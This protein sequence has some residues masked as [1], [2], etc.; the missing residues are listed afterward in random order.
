[1]KV[2]RDHD[3]LYLQEDRKQ[4]TKESFKFIVSKASAHLDQYHQPRIADI[5]CATGDFLYYLKSL[6][7]ES[8][9]TGIDVMPELLERAAAEVPGVEFLQGNIV[10]K[11]TLPKG[12]F[13]AVFMNGVY[14]IFDDFRPCLE[15]ALELADRARDGKLFVFGLFNPDD[16][17]VLV[18]V[19]NSA[20]PHDAPWQ[21]GWN[22]FSRTSVQHHLEKLGVTSSRFHEFEIGIDLPRHESDPLRSWTF[23]YEDGSRGI[24]NGAAI[25]HHLALLEIVP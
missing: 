20:Q 19:R 24:V 6:Y 21:S 7:P 1:M 5:G 10:E 16:V 4:Q 11:E 23:R 9:L 13:D 3:A 17:D 2:I 8:E 14:T 15:N 22:C 12:R 18:K 25:V